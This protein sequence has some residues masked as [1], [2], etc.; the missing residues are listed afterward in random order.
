MWRVCICGCGECVAVAAAWLRQHGDHADGAER[1]ARCVSECS[2]HTSVQVG[3]LARLNF[4]R[5]HLAIIDCVT[6]SESVKVGGVWVGGKL[7]TLCGLFGAVRC[8][9]RSVDDVRRTSSPCRSSLSKIRCGLCCMCC[10]WTCE[11]VGGCFEL[12]LADVTRV[13]PS[14]SHTCPFC[15]LLNTR[16]GCCVDRA[17][18]LPIK[19]CRWPHETRLSSVGQCFETHH[20]AEH[21][22]MLIQQVIFPPTVLSPSLQWLQLS[23]VVLMSTRQ[24]SA[25]YVST[26]RVWVVW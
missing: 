6:A 24:P 26:D 2:T 15:L 7:A 14:A 9:S 12:C 25:C 4:D 17:S 19:A 13:C 23:C 5:Y 20:R 16:D 3:S 22:H 1:W 11:R 21:V 18:I 8:D 10:V